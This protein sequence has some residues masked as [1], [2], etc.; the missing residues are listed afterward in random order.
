MAK[1]VYKRRKETD[2]SVLNFKVFFMVQSRTVSAAVS[3]QRGLERLQVVCKK[4]VKQS[5]AAASSS[6]THHSCF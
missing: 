1:P 4:Q 3:F 2:F 5:S 6:R